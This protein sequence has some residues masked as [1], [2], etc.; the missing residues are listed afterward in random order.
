M[1]ARSAI[2]GPMVVL[3]LLVVAAAAPV[4]QAASFPVR[5]IKRREELCTNQATSV[6]PNKAIRA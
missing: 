1:G 2:T 5:T 3:L 6:T 4:A